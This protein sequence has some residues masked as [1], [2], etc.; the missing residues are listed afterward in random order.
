MVTFDDA[1]LIT[2]LQFLFRMVGNR[3]PEQI[4]TAQACL[5]NPIFLKEITLDDIFA[6]R[7]AS[8]YT[9]LRSWPEYVNYF[10]SRYSTT[11]GT[12]KTLCGS[13]I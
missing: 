4:S 5:L 10:L 9:K 1:D 12:Q 11:T 2:I 13:K 8:S 3:D 7:N 6:A